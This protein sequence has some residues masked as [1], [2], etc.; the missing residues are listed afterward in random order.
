MPPSFPIRVPAY[1]DV[2][3][4]Y[5]DVRAVDEVFSIPRTADAAVDTLGHKVEGHFLRMEGGHVRV[6]AIE[7]AS[8]RNFEDRHVADHGTD[9]TFVMQYRFSG[10]GTST[11]IRCATCGESEDVTDPN[12]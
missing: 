10:L 7:R 3:E 5:I 12:W 4:D 8:I 11:E 1:V 9:T 2:Y 6:S